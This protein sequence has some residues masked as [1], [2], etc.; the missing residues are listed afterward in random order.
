MIYA[1]HA[2][3]VCR[4]SWEAEIRLMRQPMNPNSA[5]EL[6][7]PSSSGTDDFD[8]SNEHNVAEEAAPAAETFA[9]RRKRDRRRPLESEQRRTQNRN[10]AAR[11]RLRQQ[12]RLDGLIRREAVLKQRVSELEIEVLVL[13]RGRAGLPLPE[14]D[15]VSASIIG[16]LKDV[17]SL[18]TCLSRYTTE[19]QLLIGDQ[20]ELEQQLP[21]EHSGSPQA[22]SHPEP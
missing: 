7:Q 8:V 18:R 17:D 1:A 20:Q 2:D 6:E 19:S 9:G 22:Q 21:S 15:S 14:R 12:Q 5:G 13:R 10:A 3:S 16:M 4:L 11:H